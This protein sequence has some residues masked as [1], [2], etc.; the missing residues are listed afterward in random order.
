MVSTAMAVLGTVLLAWFL[1]G[2]QGGAAGRPA[3]PVHL[4]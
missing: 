4:E 1:R 2:R 3:Q